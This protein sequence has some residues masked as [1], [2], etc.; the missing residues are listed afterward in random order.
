MTIVR[1]GTIVADFY[2]N[3]LYPRD[4]LHV[5]HSVTKSI[6][7]ALVGIAI[8][9]GHIDGVD[10]RLLDVFPGREVQNL[11]ARK[12]RITIRDL[13]SMQTGLHSRDS[14]LYAHEG[15]F[16]LQ[17]SEDWLQFALD[18]P[19]AAEPGERFDYS[20]ISTFLLAVILMETTGH[21]PLDFAN[22]HLFAPLGIDDVRWEWNSVGQPIAWARMW[23]RPNDLAKL[24][25]L[26]LQRGRWKGEQIVPSDW[27]H[28]SV[29]PFAYPPTAVDVLNAD[30]S[31][32]RD[33]S[34]RS[35]VATRFLRPFSDG[36][37]YQW[38]LD[39]DGT[40]AAMGTSGQFLIVAPE[41][42]LVFVAMSK[43]RG[44]AQFVP[45]RLFQDFVLPAV[46]S[47]AP[48]P[49]NPSALAKLR[50]LAGPPELVESASPVAKLPGVATRVSG[51]TYA[52]E[53][54]PFNTDQIRFVFDPERDY[55][56]LNYTARETWEVRYDVGL[57]GVRRFTETNAGVFAAVGEWTSEDTFAVDVE[58]VGY[59][60]FD[61]W[62]FT[63][64]R[65]AI[66]V[67]EFSISGDYVYAGKAE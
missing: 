38:W 24:G 4:E 55:A 6:V 25:L 8:E 61:R 41:Q 18:L 9:K 35:W 37:G 64:E 39:R 7:S 44:L 20:N 62:E 11:D 12:R 49:E 3:P 31:P 13:L 21:D 53:T 59:S 48:L 42:D 28:E 47:D 29:T 54:N 65:G 46:L 56:E 57:D 5:L 66:R 22:K 43:S 51:V 23:L 2:N 50:A 10:A 33:A 14:Y 15:L 45:A 63:F 16:A 58:L 19:M 67:T 17:H 26:Y 40:Y 1:N 27:V 52:M 30:M 34:T 60:T 32:N 36:Y